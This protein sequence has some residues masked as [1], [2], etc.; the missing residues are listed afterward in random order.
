IFFKEAVLE[1]QIQLTAK[2][3]AQRKL[4]QQVDQDLQKEDI[5]QLSYV[6]FFNQQLTNKRFVALTFL[7]AVLFYVVL[8]LFANPF[9]Q[10]I[11]E[12]IL[13][14]FIVIVGVAT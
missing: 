12:R 9:L 2:H 13:Q 8:I 6:Q 3:L 14:S 7:P 10:F 11:I 1:S 5:Q 4:Q